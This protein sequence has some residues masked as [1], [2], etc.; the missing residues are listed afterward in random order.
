MFGEGNFKWKHPI[1]SIITNALGFIKKIED[2]GGGEE[3]PPP[4]LTPKKLHL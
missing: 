3:N 4:P 2:I 1:D